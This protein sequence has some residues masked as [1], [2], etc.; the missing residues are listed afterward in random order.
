MPEPRIKTLVRE[1]N[2]QLDTGNDKA[3]QQ[4][5][6]EWLKVEERLKTDIELLAAELAAQPG[7]PVKLDPISEMV[8]KM[9]QAGYAPDKIKTLLASQGIFKIPDVPDPQAK[10]L[11]EWQLAKMER[12]VTLLAQVQKEIERFT[13][14][15]AEPVI[16]QLS[17]DSAFAGIANSLNLIS[18]VSGNNEIVGTFDR[19]GVEAV[20][21]IVAISRGNLPL[22]KILTSAY[23]LTAT[24]IT[25]RLIYGTAMGWNP[26][27]TAKSMV[28]DGLA[29]GLN[30]VLLVARDQQIRSYREASRS[31]YQKSNV[32]KRYKRMAALQARTC[33]ACLALDG[34]I[35]DTSSLMPLH[36]QDR[37]STI[38]IVEGFPEPTWKTGE[39]WFSEQPEAVQRQILGKGK[40]EAWSQ[41]LF[42]FRDVVKITD[43]KTWGPGAQVKSLKELLGGPA[44]KT[45]KPAP[46][47]KPKP[48]PPAP[49]APIDTF[50][51]DIETLQD[52]RSLGGSTG[53][54]LV[55]D[56]ATG[57]KYVMKTG[58]SPDHIRSEAAADAAYKAMGVDVPDFKLYETTKGPVKLA[59]YIDG[60]SI[61]SIMNSD[62]ARFKTITKQIQKHFAADVLLSN[63]DVVGQGYDNI[64][65]DKNNTVWRIDNGG[66]LQFRAQGGLKAKWNEHPSELWTLRDVKT[67]V[68][69]SKIFGDLTFDE[70]AKQA[71][72]LGKY[73]ADVLTALSKNMQT[74]MGL[75]VIPTIAGRFDSL[76]DLGKMSQDMVKGG[77]N[78]GYVDGFAKHS[79]GLR[80]SGVTGALPASLTHSGVKVFDKSGKE[81]DDLRGASSIIYKV[82]DYINSSGGDYGII[83]YWS[84]EQAGSSWSRASQSLKYLISQNRGG[85]ADEY[86]WLNGVDEAK[87][88]Y[89][90]TIKKL[91]QQKYEDTMQMWHAFNHE[92]LRNV[93]FERNNRTGGFVEVIRTEPQFVLGL[94]GINKTGQSAV[95][96]RGAAES[97]SVYQTVVVA[98]NSLTLQNVPHHMIMGTY[99]TERYAGSSTSMFYG[100]RENEFVFITDGIE[101]TYVG[102]VNSGVDVGEYWKAK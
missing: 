82:K 67:N 95:I 4:M 97:G 16:D 28:A 13:G 81:W 91:G 61:E 66:S 87:K 72:N 33:A 26:R 73:K 71:V 100:D 65:V 64:L 37:C 55:V 80:N 56:P 86:F 12:Y 41:G 9:Q 15:T 39:E 57:Q 76:T 8:L 43:N 34:T 38:P 25:D 70:I 30:H 29:Q 99:F 6:A 78:W 3:F 14:R 7:K 1:F 42:N 62:P 36:P 10:Q 63:W 18:A 47:P 83:E 75:Q 69:T 11:K 60:E 5:A 49:P 88:Q 85:R 22:A 92:L 31:Q 19:L 35:Y 17:K 98:G 23:P 46:K 51:T 24:A 50:P 101:A 44:P 2:R 54:M 79:V 94:N 27:K 52:V 68:Q 53:A 77:W 89:E 96:K 74:G 21:N 90:N 84:G 48:E 32:V 40:Y 20:Q 93:D 45:P 102:E 59:K 58:K